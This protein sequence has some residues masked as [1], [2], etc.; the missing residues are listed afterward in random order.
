MEGEQKN[1]EAG[2]IPLCSQSETKLTPLKGK[3]QPWQANLPEW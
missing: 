3:H 1:K 2:L